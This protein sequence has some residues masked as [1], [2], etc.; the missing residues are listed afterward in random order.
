MDAPGIK[1]TIAT[2]QNCVNME[3]QMLPTYQVQGKKLYSNKNFVT[4]ATHFAPD[5]DNGV[6]DLV[7]ID[8]F[9]SWLLLFVM[10]EQP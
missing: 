2:N 1:A 5:A 3:I 6:S 8:V 4:F 7:G 9:C 10:S